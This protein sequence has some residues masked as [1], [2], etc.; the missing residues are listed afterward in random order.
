M[1]NDGSPHPKVAHH[2]TAGTVEYTHCA[3]ATGGYE[4]LTVWGII[5]RENF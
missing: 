2:L 4:E 3:I 1:N 5:Q